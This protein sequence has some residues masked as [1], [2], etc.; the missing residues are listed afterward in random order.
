MAFRFSRIVDDAG[1]R[2]GDRQATLLSQEIDVPTAIEQNM[3]RL[4]ADHDVVRTRRLRMHD[5]RPCK[6][7]VACLATERLAISD[8]ETVG[9]YLI[10]PLAQARGVHLNRAVERITVGEA[11]PE[12][13]GLLHIEAGNA[14]LRLDRV[15]HS[16]DGDPIEWRIAECNLRDEYYLVEMG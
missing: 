14:V 1:C 4:G 5:G 7:E 2:V 13:A 11:S 16:A 15:I 9:D 12:V 6:Y 8:L 10:V 3:L